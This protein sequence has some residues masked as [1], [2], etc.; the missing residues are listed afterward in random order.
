MTVA[1]YYLLPVFWPLY[2][3]TEAAVVGILAPLAVF[4]TTQ[5]LLNIIPA[6]II[7]N[8]VGDW[9]R[10]RFNEP[11]PLDSASIKT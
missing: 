10:L 1:T 4:N 7:Y 5:A 8:R 3:P 6:Q 11:K 2:Y 9:W